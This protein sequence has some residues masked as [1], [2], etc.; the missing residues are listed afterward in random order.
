[1]SVM[2]HVTLTWR[3]CVF[4]GVIPAGTASTATAACRCPAACTGRASS[5]GSA[6]VNPAG[7]VASVTKVSGGVTSDFF[8]QTCLSHIFIPFFWFRLFSLSFSSHIFLKVYLFSNIIC[9]CF[10]P[11]CVLGAAAMSERSYL[12]DGGQR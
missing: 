2:Y 1:M 10:R 8:S 5:R 11:P 9:C 6:A 12:C 3:L 7:G 4:P